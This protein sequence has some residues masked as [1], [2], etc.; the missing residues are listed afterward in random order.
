MIA[1]AF[2]QRRKTLLSL[3]VHEPNV[4]AN[5]QKLLHMFD[6]LGLPPHVRGEEL[7]LKDY[8]AL[9]AELKG[10]VASGRCK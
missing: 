7:L 10:Q 4:K 2:R 1:L 3:L 5:R 9:A 6:Q 8:L